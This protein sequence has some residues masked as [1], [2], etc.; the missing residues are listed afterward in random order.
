LVGRNPDVSTTAAFV[1]RPLGQR[2]ARKIVLGIKQLVR[3]HVVAAS[4]ALVG[5]SVKGIS[6]HA[7]ARATNLNALL[8]LLALS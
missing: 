8:H 7:L 3:L 6:E 4:D 2:L 1:N 5:A